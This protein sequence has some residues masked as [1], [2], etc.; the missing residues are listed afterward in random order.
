MTNATKEV[1]SHPLLH[2]SSIKF[3]IFTYQLLF[4]QPPAAEK[5]HIGGN[6]P[7]E[8]NLIT[9]EARYDNSRLEPMKTAHENPKSTISES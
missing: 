5:T 2:L 9:C 1:T 7:F 8:T 4:P 6:F 3:N